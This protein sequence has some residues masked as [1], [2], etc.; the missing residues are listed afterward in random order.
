MRSAVISGPRSSSEHGRR[1]SRSAVRV[2]VASSP[3]MIIGSSARDGRN[4]RRQP[5]PVVG[6]PRSS[7]AP[8]RGRQRGPARGRRPPRRPAIG[9]GGPRHSGSLSLPARA[10]AARSRRRPAVVRSSSARAGPA[11]VK[12]R[13]RPAVIVGPRSSSDRGRRRLVAARSG[14]PTSTALA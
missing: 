3:P 4:G 1:P 8:G 2:I 5:A 14:T 9:S 13:H 12:S 6:S 11:A 10:A 7:S